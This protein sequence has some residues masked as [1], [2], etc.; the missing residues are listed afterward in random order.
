MCSKGHRFLL[1]VMQGFG[2]QQA[3]LILCLRA[4]DDFL[5]LS[6]LLMG[7]TNDII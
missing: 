6:I 7:D 4:N 3:M 2:Q 5:D 1:T